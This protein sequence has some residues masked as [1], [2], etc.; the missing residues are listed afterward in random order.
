VRPTRV[1]VLALLAGA[2]A[3]T[4]RM[5]TLPSGDPAR[6]REVFIA[7]EG[8]HCVLCHVAPGIG[9]AGNIGP[10]MDG[11]GA[12]LDAAALRARISDITRFNPDSVMPTF[13]RVDGMKRVA[14][15][16]A[17]K[18]VLTAAQ[19]EDLVAYLGTLR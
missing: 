17:G 13:H 3:S 15:A 14:N 2:C 16:Y 18:P 4:D 10:S 6:G 8:G 9:S 11:I 19:V 12:R 1:L 7:R 5:P